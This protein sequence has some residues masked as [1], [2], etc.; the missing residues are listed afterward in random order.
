METLLIDQWLGDLDAIE[1]LDE[2]S[3]TLVRDRIRALEAPEPVR[4]RALLVASELGR[5][6]LRHARRG[7]VASRTIARHGR[8]GIEI[9]AVDLGEGITDVAGALDA[10]A[11]SGQ[12]SLGVGVGSVKRLAT[13]VDIDVR[14]GE[15]TCFR[16]RLFD[17]SVPRATE[18]GIYGRPFPGEDRSGDH[19]AFAR[20][21]DALTLVVCDGLGHGPSAREAADAAVNVFDAQA[22]ETPVAIVEACHRELGRTRGVVMTAVRLDR[23][24]RLEVASVGNVETLVTAF[25]RTRRFGGTSATVGGRG[26]PLKV[27]P[28]MSIL[29]PEEVL[30]LMTDGLLTRASVEDD[31][32]LL[33]AHPVAIAQHMLTRFARPNDDALVLAVR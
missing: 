32:L 27:R 13:E 4:D 26:G 17:P 21:G 25:R 7:H 11:R 2:A 33:R 22:A 9:V 8:A 30:V 15:G 5:N 28:E 23:D 16:A 6:H 31:A 14:L 19:A 18:V 10:P 29:E 1:V 20:S 24:A 3:L 12:G